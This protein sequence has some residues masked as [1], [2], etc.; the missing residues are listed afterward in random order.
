MKEEFLARPG[1]FPDHK[2]LELL[3]FYCD[4]RG[5]TNPTAHALMD[6]FGSIDR[7]LDALPA[8]LMKVPGIGAHAV[9]LLKAV[10][11]VSGRYVIARTTLE[12]TVNG[13]KGAWQILRP[14]FFGARTER[15]A[16]LCLDGKGRSL[17]A[18]LI[19]EGNVNATEIT[20]RL[21]VEAALSLNASGVILAH[22]HVSGVALPS[23][24][25]K[26]TTR[27]LS[28]VLSTVG[29]ELVDHMIFVDDDMVSLR[30]SGFKFEG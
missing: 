24:A 2:V 4:P 5:D 29:I 15:S 11:E 28:R 8:E 26:A 9:T 16:V 12:E 20:T 14:Y 21:V 6:R 23:D 22:N 19:T 7:V 18:R 30:D 27:Y 13:T 3:L 25:D 17:G 1:S 10:K